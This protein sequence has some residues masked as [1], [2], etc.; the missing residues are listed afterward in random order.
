MKVFSWKSFLAEEKVCS[1]F[2][3]CRRRLCVCIWDIGWMDGVKRDKKV[4]F[5]LLFVSFSC[6][7]VSE[8]V[9]RG[10]GR[11]G[12]KTN[13]DAECL[14]LSFLWK[15][16]FRI[17]PAIKE[18]KLNFCNESY[19]ISPKSSIRS[20]GKSKR[21]TYCILDGCHPWLVHFLELG[22]ENMSSFRPREKR[23]VHFSREMEK[24]FRYDFFSFER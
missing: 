14:L 22:T 18:A 15:N 8:S 7:C 10:G 24:R 9:Y 5:F 1:F 17:H 13:F 16:R 12:G 4:F 23:Y 3:T 21:L 20:M 11:R 6:A 19:W 2:F